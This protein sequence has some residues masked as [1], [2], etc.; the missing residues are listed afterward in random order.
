MFP[1]AS[2]SQRTGLL[3]SWGF[4][5]FL[6]FMP[7]LLTSFRLRISASLCL[8]FW[9]FPPSFLYPPS[10]RMSFRR[11]VSISSVGCLLLPIHASGPSFCP[12]CS[13]TARVT[14]QFVGVHGAGALGLHEVV[15]GILAV[16]SHKGLH[17]N[18]M[19]GNPESTRP[20]KDIFLVGKSIR[21][22]TRTATRA[23]CPGLKAS[24]E[25]CKL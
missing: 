13:V 3:A 11:L 14:C 25:K 20:A 17:N 23:N 1:V 18:P 10:F 8:S 12:T 21:G 7:I 15:T 16:D 22:K 2:A 6:F 19:P 9:F 4:G 5:F 24:I